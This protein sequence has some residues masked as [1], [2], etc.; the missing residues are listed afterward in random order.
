MFSK[1]SSRTVLQ[2]MLHIYASVYANEMCWS[3]LIIYYLTN[4]YYKFYFIAN[5]MRRNTEDS[6]T[7]EEKTGEDEEL[8]ETEEQGLIWANA[9]LGAVAF[10]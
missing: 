6:S 8:S 3:N 5:Q 9:F 1:G 10:P 4:T 7:E 2:H